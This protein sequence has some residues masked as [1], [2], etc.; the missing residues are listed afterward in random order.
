[1]SA[2]AAFAQSGV[3]LAPEL[4]AAEQQLVNGS[5]AA[6]IAA[7]ISPKYFDAHFSLARVI[8]TTGDRRV[9][10]RFKVNEYEATVNDAVG[11]YTDEKGRRVNVHSVGGLLTTAHDITKTIPRTRAE[12][13]MRACIGEHGA[14][15]VVY[16]ASGSPPR[17]SLVFTA[18]SVPKPEKPVEHPA[19]TPQ[20]TPLAGEGARQSDTIR[21]G[22]KRKPP[23]FIGSVDLET[24]RCVKGVAQVGSPQPGAEKYDQPRP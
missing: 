19:P 10:W 16:Q 6:I 8:N 18:V 5:R 21:Q 3:A 13:A 22:G 9:V 20:A 15:A 17:A 11:S 12:R 2:G 23:L 7:G 4:T 14:G 1:M 24:G